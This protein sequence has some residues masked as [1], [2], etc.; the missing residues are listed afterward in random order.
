MRPFRPELPS[1][2][3]WQNTEHRQQFLSETLDEKR[4]V[5]ARLAEAREKNIALSSRLSRMTLVAPQAGVV[6]K[7]T[8]HTVGGVVAPG[9]VIVEIV[10]KE[11][12]SIF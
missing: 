4:D 12:E 1:I 11:V 5:D 8:A 3:P 7:L 10:P 2:R 9:D 6:H